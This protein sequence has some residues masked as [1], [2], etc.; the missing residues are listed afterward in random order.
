[1]SAIRLHFTGWKAIAL[2]LAI[3]SFPLLWRVTGRVGLDANVKVEI[4]NRLQ[5][6]LS[7][8]A[9][10]ALGVK[11]GELPSHEAGAKFAATAQG[12]ERLEIVE[13]EAK[14]GLLG[15]HYLR[16]KF[17]VPGVEIPAGEDVRYYELGFN[18]LL[19]WTVKRGSSALFFN[20]GI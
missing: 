1:M 2:L 17:R 14:Q 11:P 9:W 19:G 13:M 10:S 6:D 5:L 12:L 8:K 18:P 7:S 20:L 16:A 4:R 3:V 15:A